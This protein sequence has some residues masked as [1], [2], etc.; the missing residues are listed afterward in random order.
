MFRDNFFKM[1]FLCSVI[2]KQ[3]KQHNLLLHAIVFYYIESFLDNI[4]FLQVLAPYLPHDDPRLSP[5]I[6]E[7]V[8]NEFLQ[9][10]HEV[11]IIIFN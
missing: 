5:A 8:L 10:N 4:A 3:L 2:S 6:Y 9:L 1:S 11:I 7:M